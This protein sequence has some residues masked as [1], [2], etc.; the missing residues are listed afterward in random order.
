MEISNTHP[1]RVL[2]D[3]QRLILELRSIDLV[4]RLSFDR[5]E[6]EEAYKAWLAT[7]GNLEYRALREDAGWCTELMGPAKGGGNITRLQ[8]LVYL[9]RP[10]V[11]HVFSLPAQSDAYLHWFFANGVAE[12]ELW[13]YLTAKEKSAALVASRHYGTPG[14]RL[15][16]RWA[17]ED[18]AIS[19]DNVGGLPFG[20]NLIG[21]AFGQLGIGE[22]L[23][24]T[25][26]ALQA[27]G[28]P[29]AV[30][31]FPAG[32]NIAS[33]ATD[34]AEHIQEEGPY[35]I[36]LFCLTA[37]EH[38]RFF[39]E[40]GS[41]QL[42]GRYNIGYWPWELSQ[43]PREWSAAFDLVDEVWV[44]T[45][46]T[47][48]ALLSAQSPSIRKP[49]QWMPLVVEVPA[50]AYRLREPVS[51]AETRKRFGLP[52]AARLFCFSFDLN[53]SIHR[54]NPQAIVKAFER[55]FPAADYSAEQVG[56][57]VK[58]QPPGR[59]HRIWDNL[60]RFAAADGRI[61]IV[62]AS[63]SRLDV[64]GL[65]A[66]C[67]CF[68]S[69]HRAEGF[70]RGLAEALQLGLHL[71]A[72]DYSGNTDFC[73]RPEFSRQVSLV[74]YRLV[75]VRP[76]QYPFAIGQYWANANVRLAAQAMRQF[77]DTVREPVLVPPGGWPCFGAADLGTVYAKRL[78]MLFKE[79]LVA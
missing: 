41:R 59:R 26:R 5:P 76:G 44:S 13:G 15:L 7:S 9:G 60:K 6:N 1:G 4:G 47:R 77:T 20:V 31:D 34:V 62:E 69:L 36:N 22:D 48:D 71:I 39:A 64:L 75:K 72:T 58:V 8:E 37:I 49:V 55:A 42:A 63:L 21:H 11:Q 28:V 79:R 14:L 33:G 54:K 2:P 46:H 52:V 66:A 16:E 57:V 23:R 78:K 56:L 38:C 24:M 61:H 12:Y 53:S 45:A 65:Y 10:D 30:V 74:P 3:L 67:D 35:A 40:R 68:V 17:A 18:A 43:W 70:G 19:S 27:A 50:D 73:R 51:R 32:P 29:F 25:A